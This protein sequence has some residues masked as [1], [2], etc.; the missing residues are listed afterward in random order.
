MTKFLAQPEL[1]SQDNGCPK[2][3]KLATLTCTKQENTAVQPFP[4]FDGMHARPLS[5]HRVKT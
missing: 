2:Y 4:C 1:V 3:L 5:C